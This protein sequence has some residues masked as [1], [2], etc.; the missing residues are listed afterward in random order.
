MAKFKEGFL[1]FGL[2]PLGIINLCYGFGAKVYFFAPL[3][4]FILAL[5]GCVSAYIIFDKEQRTKRQNIYLT[6]YSVANLLFA[7][8]FIVL[9][10]LT[11]YVLTYYL[12]GAFNAFCFLALLVFFYLL[13]FQNRLFKNKKIKILIL[14]VIVIIGI[15]VFF[16]L[17]IMRVTGKPVVFDAGNDKFAVVVMTNTKSTAKLTY[18]KNGEVKTITNTTNGIITVDKVHKFYIDKEEFY[19]ADYFVEFK[20][21]LFYFPHNRYNSLIE[22]KT[23][24]IHFR[25][26]RDKQ[27]IDYI[28]YSDSHNSMNKKHNPIDTSNIDFFVFLGDTISFATSQRD[29]STLITILHNGSKGEA[30]CYYAIGNHEKRGT[31]N[32]D[33]SDILVTPNG[34][35]NYSFQYKDFFGIVMDTGEDYMDDGWI[36]HGNADYTGYGK[37]QTQWLI[38]ESEDLKAKNAKNIAFFAHVPFYDYK[39]SST[40]TYFNE[41]IGI[42]NTLNVDI[43]FNG[44]DH[45]FKY[46]ENYEKIDGLNLEIPNILV[47]GISHNF[48]ADYHTTKVNFNGTTYKIENH[49]IKNNKGKL[50]NEILINKNN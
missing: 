48:K 29:V 40:G 21:S 24:E 13:I 39:K 46:Y 4:L 34:T 44:H 38:Q 16:D 11:P 37:E 27:E 45:N 25:D 17:A 12:R 22:R 2:I 6:I 20:N 41:W 26:L 8:G 28:I 47:A 50:K 18:E 35:M 43:I 30:V 3:F 49:L 42:L 1:K 19:G 32:K 23:D 15:A 9:T 7:V 14:A 33:I 5:S 10:I 31:Y 36:F